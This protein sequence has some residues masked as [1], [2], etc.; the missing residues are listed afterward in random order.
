MTLKDLNDRLARWSLALQA[1]DLNIEHRKGKDNIVA[2]ML[3]RPNEAAEIDFFDFET[4]EFESPEYL[5]RILL[6]EE[7]GKDKFPDLRHMFTHGKDYL[8]ARKLKALNKA[9]IAQLPRLERQQLYREK[10]KERIHQAYEKATK[11]Y[12][13]KAREIRCLPGQEIYKRNFV[14]SDFSKNRNSKF[15][16]KYTKCRVTKALGNSLYALENVDGNPLGF[17]HAKDLKQ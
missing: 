10:I 5:E 3:S 13:L 9:E 17:F 6:I 7:Q 14:L 12:N 11:S 8:L 4:T 2:D 16:R 15:Y 1:F